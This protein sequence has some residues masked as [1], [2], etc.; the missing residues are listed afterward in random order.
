MITIK[1]IA[2]RA[3]VSYATVSR[4]LN[5]HRDVSETTRQLIFDL[6][7]DM[8]YQPNAIAR[9]LVKK[10]SGII[11]VVVPD[12]SNH[13]FADITI[14]VNEAADES[15]FTTMICNTDWD[16]EKEIEKLRIMV[17]QRVE[18][19]IL[20]PTA[21]IKASSLEALKLPIVL[22]W[23]AMDDGLSY[24][25]VDHEEGSRAAVEHLI[26]GGYQKIAYIG[27]APTSPSN[28]IRLQTYQ[29]VL[30]QHHLAI[31]P[32]WVSYGPFSLKSGYERMDALM[33]LVNPPD[34]VF[35]GNDFIAMGVQQYTREKGIAVPGQI[36]I[37]GFDDIGCAALP[38]IDLTTVSQPRDQ[39]GREALKALVREIDHFPIRTRQRIVIQPQLVKRSTTR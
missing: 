10:K 25:E 36:G 29:Q 7:R 4:A 6:A 1:D 2:E 32:D 16:P 34:A 13:F 39:L 12:V 22:F 17:G 37:V 3:G 26:Q 24:I 35:C 11:A 14:H 23:H 18:G 21:S 27:G 5:G 33:H 19:I 38:L 31:D 20:K 15:G 8:G 28:Q 9:G 30:R